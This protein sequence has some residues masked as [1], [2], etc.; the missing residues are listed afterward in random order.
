M[1]DGLPVALV[2]GGSRGIGRAVSLRLA[3]EGFQLVV[4]YREQQAAAEAV[5]AEIEAAGGAAW[6]LKGDVCQRDDVNAMFKAVD[7][8]HGGLDVLVNNAGRAID[9]AFAM[10]PVERF[11][12]M[13]EANFYSTVRCCQAA[14][15]LMVRKR[16]GTIINISS[17]SATRAPVGL[18][19]YAASKAAVNA[20]TIGLAREVARYGI[21]VN[22]VAPSWTDT[23]MIQDATDQARAERTRRIPMG[24]VA[25]AEEVAAAVAALVRPDMSYVTGQ[26]LGVDGGG[27]I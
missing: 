18:S 4:N 15:K 3:Q 24:R 9:G 19:A 11:S 21:R 13:M 10:T 12:A 26:I 8:R 16:R 22:A 5:C 2:T 14:V 20:V 7:S 1:S 17:S 27:I 25:S 23:E 6:P